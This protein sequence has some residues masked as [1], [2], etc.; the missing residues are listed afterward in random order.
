MT[1]TRKSL[2]AARRILGTLVLCSAFAHA[3]LQPLDN[4]DL[5]NIGGQ[6]GAELSWLL[7][8]NHTPWV[9]ATTSPTQDCSNLVYCR[10]AVAFNNRTVEADGV[11]P[12][13]NNTGR[14]LWLVFKGIQG[15]IN[16]QHMKLEG[17]DITYKQDI[18][19]N[20]DVTKA[21]ARFTFDP[22]RPILLRNVGFQSLAI[23]RDSEM[24]E[25]AGNVPG[26]LA[27]G[28]GGSGAGAYASGKYTSPGFDFNRE[29][30]F[31]GLTMHG[32]LVL[33]GSVQMFSCPSN[34]QRC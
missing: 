23:E 9:D 13:D 30:G 28:S 22:Q 1:T 10:L 12:R 11:T 20:P 21:G 34:H 5:G 27:A 29:T 2:I 17:S 3:D 24:N 19:T 26:Y 32:N 14:K 18:T 16:V 8:L 25:G 4:E 6:G 7:Q 31:T 33:N 15:T